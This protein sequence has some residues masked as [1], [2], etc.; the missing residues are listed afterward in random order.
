MS[1]PGTKYQKA[2]S[3]ITPYLFHFIK[4]SETNPKDVLSK[5]LDEQKL[6]SKKGYNCFTASPITGL[7]KFFDTKVYNTNHPMYQ[8][9]GIGF[10][11]DLLIKNYN[12]RNI[13]YCSKEEFA[14]IP[15]ELKWRTDLLNVESYDFEWLR[16]WRTKGD[17]FD[18][19]E[20]PKDQIIVV[21][22]NANDFLDIVVSDE[23]EVCVYGD[24][25]TGDVFC[26]IESPTYKRKWK[27]FTLKQI[28]LHQNDFEL[29]DSTDNQ[30][31]G[32][33]MVKNIHETVNLDG[34]DIK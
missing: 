32:E 31:I 28:L 11:R 8:P 34:L 4:G 30:N 16:E 12:A 6:C 14:T 19:S 21:A 5:I 33:S 23:P 29:L 25:I 1:N 26:E 7:K 13:I 22:Q 2:K 10:A 3:D 9:Y 18:F 24:P 20:F 27:G 17:V 15:E